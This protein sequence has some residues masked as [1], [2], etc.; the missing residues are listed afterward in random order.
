MSFIREWSRSWQVNNRAEIRLKGMLGFAMRAGKVIIGTETVLSAVSGREKKRPRLLLVAKNASPATKKKLCSQAEF[1]G[2]E[3]AEINI[4]SEELG[5][6]LGKLYAPAVV[7]V[8]DERFAEEI[9]SAM[10]SAS[11]ISDQSEPS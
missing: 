5:R 9:R 2:V 11:E 4:E 7:A 3:L 6:M 10:K 8:I 1:Y